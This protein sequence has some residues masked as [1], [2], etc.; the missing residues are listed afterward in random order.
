MERGGRG[1]MTGCYLAPPLR[2]FLGDPGVGATK[3]P[4]TLIL[5]TETGNVMGDVTGG[6]PSNK[7]SLLPT[8]NKKK[9]KSA[10]LCFQPGSTV[11]PGRSFIQRTA[12]V[13]SVVSRTPPMRE[14]IISSSAV[15]GVDDTVYLYWEKVAPFALKCLSS[16]V[17]TETKPYCSTSTC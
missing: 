11:T 10:V 12:T 1:R 14:C 7:R 6:L 15:E 8:F 2:P 4:P 5:E 3:G 9:K 17:S 13:N 16:L